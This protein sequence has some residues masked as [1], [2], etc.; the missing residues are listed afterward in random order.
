MVPGPL[1]ATVQDDEVALGDGALEL[2]R[3]NFA[4]KRGI[5]G[6]DE[7]RSV[8]RTAAILAKQ[9]RFDDAL[10]AFEV[11]DFQKQRGFWLHEMLISK[12]RT[13]SAA[14][15]KDQAAALFRQVVEDKTATAAHR[16]RAEDALAND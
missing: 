9:R 5:G 11:V 3:L 1:L 10:A 2:Y 14:G 13:L 8:D 15:R 16:K 6:A 12:G 4:G 7:F